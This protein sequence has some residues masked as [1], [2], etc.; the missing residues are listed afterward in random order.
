MSESAGAGEGVGA[1]G[2]THVEVLAF[3]SFGPK[4]HGFGLG[5]V[6]F[7]KSRH[8]FLVSCL[9]GSLSE[10]VLDCQL[11]VPIIKR[12]QLAILGL[13]HASPNAHWI[14]EL[15]LL[16]EGRPV[17]CVE[18]PSIPFSFFFLCLSLHL[19]SYL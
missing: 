13:H 12:D 8:E 9:L 15:G 14:L 10:A 3:Q 5:V 17:G 18:E 2:C 19:L 11:L 4:R 1:S 16:A 7:G 6:A